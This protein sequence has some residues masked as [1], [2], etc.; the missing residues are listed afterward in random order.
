MALEWM[1]GFDWYTGGAAGNAPLNQRYQDVTSG[2]STTWT[3]GTG[4]FSGRCIQAAGAGA[5]LRINTGLSA[6][7]TFTYAFAYKK[8]TNLSNNE[9]VFG[10]LSTTTYQNSIRTHAN[11]SVTYNLGDTATVV[12]G[13]TSAAGVITVGTWHH[14]EVEVVISDTVG[15]VRLWVD[16]VSAFSVTNQD[17][18]NVAGTANADGVQFGGTSNTGTQSFDDFHVYT[19]ATEHKGDMRIETLVPESDTADSDWTPSA[20]TDNYAMVDES[21]PDADTTYV[22]SATVTDLDKYELTNLTTTPTTIVAVQT[23]MYARKDDATARSVRTLID[24]GGTVANH[25][26]RA[27]G[28]SYAPFRDFNTTDPN[29]GGAWTASAVDALKVGIEVMV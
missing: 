25:T 4:R 14:I 27:M 2:A 5:V 12:T 9:R 15:E 16:G 10:L 7:T 17:T 8:D 24:S 26:T 22:R 28:A 6:R 21:Q 23:T 20:G 29:G 11:G 18:R 1:D 13:C 3:M 19:T